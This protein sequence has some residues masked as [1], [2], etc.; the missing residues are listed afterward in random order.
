M[1]FSIVRQGEQG[2]ALTADASAGLPPAALTDIS[3]PHTTRPLASTANP[4]SVKNSLSTS[5]P[6][7]VMT[8]SA[9]ISTASSVSTGRRRPE[10]SGSP[11]VIRT[12]RSVPSRNAFGASSSRKTTPSFS[13][14][15]SSSR[16]AGI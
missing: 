2:A 5:S 14:S 4:L 6:T 3:P 16:S 15:S 12:Q 1:E 8:V 9:G 13:A 7:A 10:A 11:S